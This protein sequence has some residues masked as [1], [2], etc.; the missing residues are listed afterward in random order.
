MQQ[1]PWTLRMKQACLHAIHEITPL[2]GIKEKRDKLQRGAGGDFTATIDRIAETVIFQDLQQYRLP[3]TLISEELG[4]KEW[5][6]EKIESP[7][8]YFILDPIDGS[9]NALLGIPFAC[10]SI[11]LAS[12]ESS[13]HIEAACVVNIFTKDWYWA[14]K[15]K[16]AFKNDHTIHC[17]RIA[18]GSARFASVDFDPHNIPSTL[19]NPYQEIF[20]DIKILRMMGSCALELCLVAEGALDMYFDVRGKLRIVDFIAGLLILREAG[21]VLL[22]SNPVQQNFTCTSFELHSRYSLI[23]IP[24][25]LQEEIQQRRKKFQKC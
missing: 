14:E 1:N 19:L 8:L 6:P 17:N 16:G 7:P 18:S 2:I 12:Q 5:N 11:A 22:D 23:A 21:G 3:F 24:V 10:I 13:E 15:G 25:D 20:P 9:T 4:R